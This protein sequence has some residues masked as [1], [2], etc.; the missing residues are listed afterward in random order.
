M[1]LKLPSNVKKRPRGRPKTTNGVTIHPIRKDPEI[2]RISRA[3]IELGLYFA[4][5]RVKMGQKGVANAG[6]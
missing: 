6:L 5:E 1:S 2:E 4:K 3:F